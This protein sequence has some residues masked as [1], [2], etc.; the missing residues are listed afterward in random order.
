MFHLG[1]A[2]SHHSALR[3]F[4]PEIPASS[5][6]VPMKRVQNCHSIPHSGTGSVRLS[7]WDESKGLHEKQ[8]K[9]LRRNVSGKQELPGVVCIFPSSVYFHCLQIYSSISLLLLLF[10]LLDSVFICLGCFE[11]NKKVSLHIFLTSALTLSPVLEKSMF[12]S[13][14]HSI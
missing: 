4:S 12:S 8:T 3:C 9:I 5:H 11:S 10:R 13:F 7:L 6:P 2:S 1:S 14:L